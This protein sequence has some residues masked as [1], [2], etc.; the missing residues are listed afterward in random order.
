MEAEKETKQ[1]KWLSGNAGNGPVFPIDYS[2]RSFAKYL[3]EDPRLVNR[4]IIDHPFFHEILL[5]QFC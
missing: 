2:Q 1:F 5:Q 4:Y 3:N